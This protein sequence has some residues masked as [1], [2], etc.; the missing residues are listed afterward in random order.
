MGRLYVVDWIIGLAGGLLLGV[1]VSAS[2]LDFS[3]TPWLPVLIVVFAV[4]VLFGAFRI[5]SKKD[6]VLKNMVDERLVSVIDKSARNALVITYLALLGIVFY[7]GAPDTI[8]AIS[9]KLILLDVAIGL[10]AF[11]AS[12][13]FYYYRKG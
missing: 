3:D 13:I 1:L 4:L 5:K 6:L 11:Y 9:A 7:K 10:L 12:Y 8:S 2:G